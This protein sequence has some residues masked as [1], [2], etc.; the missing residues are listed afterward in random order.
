VKAEPKAIMRRV[1]VFTL[2]CLL[3]ALP[4][5]SLFKDILADVMAPYHTMS[6]NR[7]EQ[8]E[9]LRAQMGHYEN[10]E[11]KTDSY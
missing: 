5:C 2:V 11:W 10:G 3:S 4:G 6:N 7:E 8:R 9:H 1:G